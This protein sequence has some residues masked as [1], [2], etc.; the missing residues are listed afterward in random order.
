MIAL[1]PVESLRNSGGGDEIVAVEFTSCIGI[2]RAYCL[3]P[4]C[5]FF[6][7]K[8]TTTIMLNER[9]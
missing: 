9:T 5:T 1:V 4:F 2:Q 6:V 3:M 7:C 8:V